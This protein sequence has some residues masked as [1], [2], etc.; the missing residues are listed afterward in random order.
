M[1]KITTL[2]FLFFF[3]LFLGSLQVFAQSSNVPYDPEYYHLI[4]RY[5]IKQ[6]NFGKIF[7]AVKPY[8][9]QEIASFL[10]GFDSTYNGTLSEADKYNLSYLALDNWEHMS[11]STIADVK[12]PFLKYFYRSKID[13]ANVHEKDFDVHINPVVLF[14]AGDDN[15]NAS[16]PYVSQRGVVMRGSIAGKVGFYLQASDN[17]ERLP[18]Y[19][20][21]YSAM[22]NGTFPGQQ[23]NKTEGDVADYFNAQGYITFQLLK[24]Y[25]GTEFGRGRN[26]IGNGYRSLILSDFANDYTYWKLNTRVWHL[27]YT[28]IFAQMNTSNTNPRGGHLPKK[29]MAMHH[30]GWNITKNLNIGLFEQIIFSRTD[31]IGNNTF[32]ISYLNPLIFYRSLEHG[33]GDVDNVQIGLDAKWNI[34]NKV[35]LYCQFVV[36]DMSVANF[37]KGF[38]GNKFAYQFGAKY[39]DAFGL[40]NLDLQGEVNVVDPYTYSHKNTTGSSNLPNG[41]LYTNTAHYYQELTHPNGANFYEL[42]GILRYRPHFLPKVSATIKGMYR[43]QGMNELDEDGN[44]L[45]NH[46]S[47]IFLDY[48]TAPGGPDTFGVKLLQGTKV[49]TM[50]VDATLTYSPFHNIFIDLRGVFRNTSSDDARYTQNENYLSA[51][52]RWNIGQR[53][54]DF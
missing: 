28:N 54:Y 32:D 18:F 48:N 7:T 5:E 35:Q 12:K 42:I 16:R 40:P 50:Y 19:A 46:G 24:D 4:D 11:D 15:L 45:V 33:L 14:S 23:W 6:K 26:F 43:E 44:V 49:R 39:I 8:S 31:S 27:E 9:R 47:N 34:W 3:T 2:K 51:A 10:E 30:L 37:G 38:Y 17:Q 52:V 41:Q 25:I 1:I 20:Q 22:R 13:F 21:Q 36:D 29:Y 53:L